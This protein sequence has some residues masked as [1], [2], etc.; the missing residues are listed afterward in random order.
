MSKAA[1]KA[2][3]TR[4]MKAL[5]QFI[6]RSMV[7]VQDVAVSP[8]AMCDMRNTL[9][10]SWEAFEKAQDELEA[11]LEEDEHLDVQHDA[12]LAVE[13]QQ[14]ALEII[15]FKKIVI[16]TYGTTNI[17]EE[18]FDALHKELEAHQNKE[19]EAH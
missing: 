3:Q 19:R 18:E 17:S 2:K 1:A 11:F 9:I 15:L 14:D 4:K 16:K 6:E 8:V 13:A 7:A 12:Y 10:T 5:R